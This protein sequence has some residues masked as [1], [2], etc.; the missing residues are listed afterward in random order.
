MSDQKAEDHV[1]H[2]LN[3][4]LFPDTMFAKKLFIH[5]R[6]RCTIE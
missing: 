4:Q 5:S 6:L 2:A 3:M 1:G